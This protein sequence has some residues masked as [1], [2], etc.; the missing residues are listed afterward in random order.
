MRLP[1]R[2]PQKLAVSSPSEQRRDESDDDV[3]TTGP[4]REIDRTRKQ[5]SIHTK[6]GLLH[7][8]RGEERREGRRATR[9]REEKGRRTHQELKQV[10]AVF[11]GEVKE[12]EKRSIAHTRKR[13]QKQTTKRIAKKSIR[14]RR[15]RRRRRRKSFRFLS[16]KIVRKKHHHHP[17]EEEEEKKN[18]ERSRTVASFRVFDASRRSRLCPRRRRKRRR[19]RR[20]SRKT[21]Y[22]GFI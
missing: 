1:V 16:T 3:P 10:I 12:R 18:E 8:E 5:S 19:R 11:V 21:H 14:R 20:A 2:T 13:Q 4:T 17:I 6:I 7:S 9:E 15:K 22:S